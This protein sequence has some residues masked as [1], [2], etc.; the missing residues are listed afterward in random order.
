MAGI[1]NQVAGLCILDAFHCMSLLSVCCRRM[2]KFHAKILVDLHDEAGTV[3]SLGQTGSAVHIGVTHK[4]QR[5]FHCRNTEL[6]ALIAGIIDE[7]GVLILGLHGH[8][9]RADPAFTVLGIYL[10]PVRA[11]LEYEKCFSLRNHA[12][13][14]CLGIRLGTYIQ[15]LRVHSRNA[16]SQLFDCLSRLIADIQKIAEHI[17]GHRA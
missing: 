3:D 9:L 2:R 10:D 8:I 15:D 11:L 13:N 14:L 5:I 17:A 6:T 12:K 7:F 4:L 1:T 16:K